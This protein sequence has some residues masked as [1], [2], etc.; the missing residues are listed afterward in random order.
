MGYPPVG[1]FMGDDLSITLRLMPETRRLGILPEAAY[2]YRIG[3]NTSRDVY[4]R[5]VRYRTVL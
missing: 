3:G 2:N 1:W 5:Q 4:K